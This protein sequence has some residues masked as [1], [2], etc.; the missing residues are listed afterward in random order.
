MISVFKKHDIL[1]QITNFFS[2]INIFVHTS[3]Y[4]ISDKNM[5]HQTMSFDVK[6]RKTKM[7]PS[8]TLTIIQK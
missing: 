5:Y 4:H 1:Y 2:V 8:D 3:I 7:T 6:S